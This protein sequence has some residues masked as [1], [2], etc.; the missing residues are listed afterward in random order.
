MTHQ[1][2]ED[3]VGVKIGDVNNTVVANSL[4][5]ADDR[6]VGTL[7]FDVN[8]RDVKAGEEF[9]VTFKAC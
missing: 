7:L 6:T 2:G 4:M 9:E 1:F 5:V 3:F 8:D